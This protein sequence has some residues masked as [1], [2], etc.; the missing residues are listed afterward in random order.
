MWKTPEQL[1]KLEDFSKPI[2]YWTFNDKCGVLK[3]N[4]IF[5]GGNPKNVGT[6]EDHIRNWKHK[7]EKYNI[8][9]WQFQ[10]E[11]APTI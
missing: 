10:E 1:N 8:K 2:L 5:F 7:C 11:I 6:L 3:D 4:I 9:Y